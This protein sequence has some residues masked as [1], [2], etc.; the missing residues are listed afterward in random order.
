MF[1]KKERIRKNSQLNSP[2]FDF[3]RDSTPTNS[4]RRHPP[5]YSPRNSSRLFFLI[6][7]I[8][9]NVASTS[10]PPISRRG[11][12]GFSGETGRIA[13]FVTFTGSRPYR[14]PFPLI[15][16]LPPRDLR[17]NL[18][19]RERTRGIRYLAT[20]H[21]RRCKGYRQWRAARNSRRCIVF[22]GV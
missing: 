2:S 9:K 20:P 7:K 14:P 6:G 21:H 1:R 8:Y 5:T 11:R 17:P 13:R 16:L 18:T 4:K 10:V 15:R 3:P 22:S 19:N 12:V